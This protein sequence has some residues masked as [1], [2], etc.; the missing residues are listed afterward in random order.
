MLSF[1]TFRSL[2]IIVL[3]KLV[4]DNLLPHVEYT[5]LLDCPGMPKPVMAT[6]KPRL[7]NRLSLLSSCLKI[8]YDGQTSAAWKRG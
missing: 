3:L 2:K 8:C 6:Y 5:N 7:P 4:L 1:I